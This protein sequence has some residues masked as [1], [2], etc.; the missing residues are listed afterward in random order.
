[1]HKEVDVVLSERDRIQSEYHR[2]EQDNIRNLYAPWQTAEIFM[3]ASRK[4]TAALMLYKAGV[5]PRPGDHCLEIGYGT[6]GWLG[7]LISWKVRECDLH[8]IELDARRAQQAQEILPVADLRVGDATSLPWGDCSFRLI[9]VSTVFTSILNSE[10]RRLV[11]AEIERVLMPGGVLLWYDFAVNNP[12]NSQVR[13]VS[14]KEL[15]QL[16]PK[17]SGS[18]KSITLAPPL[19]RVLAPKCWPLA[20]L[21]EV[22]P[23]L[24]THLM[25]VLVKHPH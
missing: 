7:D 25:G 2:R 12:E 14:R 20:S 18:V 13:K 15:K 23:W 6:L 3:Q 22:I 1:M 10:V 19:V 16:F 17:L 21:L 4:R 8:G 5:F 24:R 11:A 9:V